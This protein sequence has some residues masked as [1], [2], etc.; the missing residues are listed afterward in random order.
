LNFL[1]IVENGIE[2]VII[3][4]DGVLKSKTVNGKAVEF[5]RKK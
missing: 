2:T 3:E 5:Y 4:E 1:R